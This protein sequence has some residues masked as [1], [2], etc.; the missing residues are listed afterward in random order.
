MAHVN[1]NFAT[2]LVLCSLRRRNS[3]T[4]CK[5]LWNDYIYFGR[6]CP[7][8]GRQARRCWVV[9][10]SKL[11]LSQ[12][13]TLDFRNCN[14]ILSLR[15]PVLNGFCLHGLHVLLHVALALRQEK[16]AA[17]KKTCVI[18]ILVQMSRWTAATAHVLIG[19]LVCNYLLEHVSS[20][21]HVDNEDFFAVVLGPWTSCSASCGGGH[22]HRAVQCMDRRTSTPA[23][24]CHQLKK[25]PHR[26]RC[27]NEPCSRSYHSYHNVQ[28]E[29]K[30]NSGSKFIM[31]SQIH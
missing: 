22:Q 21:W 28:G 29:V 17:L 5:L 24:G 10:R 27:N 7:L 18:R 15:A 25:P 9:Q 1:S 20:L 8:Y 31:A 13:L 12:N 19:F 3:R 30:G 26:Q 14:H 16:S 23:E 11:P 4:R 2:I 6:R